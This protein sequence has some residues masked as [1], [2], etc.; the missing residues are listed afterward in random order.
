MCVSLLVLVLPYNVMEAF[1]RCKIED[2]WKC[3]ILRYTNR[4]P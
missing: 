1:V 3:E 2:V 4:H